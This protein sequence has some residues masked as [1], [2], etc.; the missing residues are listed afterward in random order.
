MTLAWARGVTCNSPLPAQGVFAIA[1]EAASAGCEVVAQAWSATPARRLAVAMA[2][3]LRAR[4]GNGS[5]P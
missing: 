5:L 2:D 3:G 1:G 4:R